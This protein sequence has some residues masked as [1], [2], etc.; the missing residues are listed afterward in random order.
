VARA[1][2][3][4]VA[5]TGNLL[6]VL[7]AGTIVVFLSNRPLWLRVQRYLM[8]TVLGALAVKIATDHTRPV[9]V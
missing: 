2:K 6:I 3:I 7:A 8:G 4:A 5:L 9:A 1:V